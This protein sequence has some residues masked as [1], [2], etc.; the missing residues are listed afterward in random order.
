[1]QTPIEPETYLSWK[2]VRHLLGGISRSTWWR[3]MRRGEAPL[4]IR[5]SPNRVGWSSRA[6]SVFQAQRRGEIQEP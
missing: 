6:I 5:L 2:D 3:M 1:M 4:P